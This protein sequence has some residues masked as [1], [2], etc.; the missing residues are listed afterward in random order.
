LM[1]FDANRFEQAEFKP[2]TKRVPVP[3]LAAF[4]SDSEP[5]WEVRGLTSSELHRAAEAKQRQATLQT[6][7]EALAS[8]GEKATELRKALGLDGKTTPGEIAKRQ[9][10][11]TM[12]SVCPAIDEAA[13]VK[14]SEAFPIEFL[15][16][17]NEITELTGQ[18]FD[19]VKPA[20]ASPQ[21]PASTTA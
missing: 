12:G 4:F 13:A 19:L 9:Q 1:P 5:M 21:T 8:S 17:T 7:V 6:V 15:Q 16:L 2:R 14:L 20:A 11:L 18:G 10:M 3:G